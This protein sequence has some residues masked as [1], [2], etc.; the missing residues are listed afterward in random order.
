MPVRWINNKND[1]YNA[2]E[3]KAFAEKEQKIEQKRS[4]M[5]KA[6]SFI[7]LQEE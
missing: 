4:F 5:Q 3:K 1:W 7:G 2:F 6:K